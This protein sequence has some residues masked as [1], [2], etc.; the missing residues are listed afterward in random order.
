MKKIFIGGFGACAVHNEKDMI[1]QL[2]QDRDNVLETNNYKEADIILIIDNCSAIYECLIGSLNYID[3]VLKEKK[4]N[5]EV[6]VSGCIT[7]KILFELPDNYKKILDRV[8]CINQNEVIEYVLKMIDFELDERI[9][10][11]IKLPIS[12]QYDMIKAELSPVRGCTN[13]CSFCKNKNIIDFKLESNPIEDLI[14]TANNLERNKHTKYLSI[15]SS[16]FSQY[17]IDKYKVQRAHEA[18]KILTSPENIKYVSVGEL[19]NWYPELIDEILSNEKIKIVYSSIESGSP[20]I[21]NLM[22]RPISLEK[23]IKI[24]KLIKKERPDIQICTEMIAGFPTETIDDLKMSIELIQELELFP[25]FVWR[26]YDSPQLPISKLPQHSKEYCIE[27]KLYAEEKL[28]PLVDKL[29]QNTENGEMY[30]IMKSDELKLYLTM[31]PDGS[32][33]RIRYNQVNRN[34]EV[35]EI[36][37]ANTVKIK[38][39][40]RS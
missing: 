6:I 25:S 27:S 19:I 35:D 11:E 40:K 31:L 39:L 13:S 26:Y 23:L 3:T 34:Y 24:I 28:L 7:N 36:I 21:Y 14:L 4:E 16:N 5:S 32:I 17:G 8:T 22:N 29:E 37:E 15:F 30:V 18:I 20:R 1:R 9:I 33:R 12:L 38:Q 2:F 10:R